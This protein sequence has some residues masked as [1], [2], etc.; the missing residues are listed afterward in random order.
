MIISEPSLN[1][2]TSLWD[3]DYEGLFHSKTILPGTTGSYK[4]SSLFRNNFF[5]SHEERRRLVTNPN[6]TQKLKREQISCDVLLK[7][8]RYVL[9]DAFGPGLAWNIFR[10]CDCDEEINPPKIHIDPLQLLQSKLKPLLLSQV[11]KRLRDVGVLA[12]AQQSK[13]FSLL[14][15][16]MVLPKET[17]RKMVQKPDIKESGRYIRRMQVSCVLC[18]FLVILILPPLCYKLF[19]TDQNGS[20]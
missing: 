5:V 14:K 2:N 15:K 19:I 4:L 6:L 16:Q 20:S 3:M 12:E 8:S 1:P 13:A 18:C 7:L 11:L 10:F 17:T 9:M